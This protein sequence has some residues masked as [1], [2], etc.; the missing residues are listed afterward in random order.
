MALSLNGLESQV[1]DVR[2]CSVAPGS[3]RWVF[4]ERMAGAEG[5]RV[6]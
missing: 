4:S 6:D 2:P 1:G 5:R 3:P